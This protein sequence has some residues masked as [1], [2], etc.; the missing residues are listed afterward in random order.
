VADLVKAMQR[1]NAIPV[2]SDDGAAWLEER[3]RRDEA[4]LVEVIEQGT[5]RGSTI[6]GTQRGRMLQKIERAEELAREVEELKAALKEKEAVVQA[7]DAE[8]KAL[9]VQRRQAD[10]TVHEFRRPSAHRDVQRIRQQP[11]RSD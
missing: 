2:P 10:D 7:N 3:E 9:K 4:A 8:I 1:A 6:R 5:V 11:L